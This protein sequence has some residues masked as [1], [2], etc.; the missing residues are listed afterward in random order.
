MDSY[1]IHGPG[2][3]RYRLTTADLL[4]LA[5]AV[6]GEAGTNQAG[7][8]AVAWAVIQYHALVVGPGGRRPAFSTLTAL[9]RAY[10]QPINPKW[11]S[12]DTKECQRNPQHCTERHLQR[13]AQITN[14]VWNSIPEAPRNVVQQL[15]LGTLPN[16]VPGL[17]DWKAAT[18]TGRSAWS[19]VP[20]VVVGGNE[21]GVNDWRTLYR[22]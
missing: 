15:L 16:P 19:K 10:C 1:I 8:A 21:F 13:R 14:A 22:S 3:F 18:Q 7:G 9:L 6:W 11:A 4:W 12:A 2:G 20:T 5:R 17:V